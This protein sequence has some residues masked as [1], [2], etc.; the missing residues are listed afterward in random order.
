MKEKKKNT[1]EER[2][3]GWKTWRQVIED[4]LADC[5][6]GSFDTLLKQ[7]FQILQSPVCLYEN[8]EGLLMKWVSLISVISFVHLC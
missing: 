7:I 8:N 5:M 3:A 4:V 1:T 6:K 2:Q